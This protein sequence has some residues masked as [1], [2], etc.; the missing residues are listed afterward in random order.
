M[1]RLTTESFIEKSRIVH[2]ETYDYSKVIY[3]NTI[4]NVII[5]CRYHGEFMQT[6]HNHLKGSGCMKC[7]NKRQSKKISE[8]Y[9]NKRI[10]TDIVLPD[11]YK[12][13]PVGTK[14]LVTIVD[15]EYFDYLSKYNWCLNKHGYVNNRKLGL[16]HRI[17]T[18]CPKGLMVDHKDH[19]KLNNRSNNLRICTSSRNQF[20]SISTKG[21]SIYK[22]VCWLAKE[23]RW[24]ANIRINR[25][26]IYLGLF[27]NEDDAA[28]AYNEAAILYF[29][30][31]AY[32]NE[33]K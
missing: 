16:I 11:R 17:I 15:S 30:D 13:I 20:N 22:G 8:L 9:S 28:K 24:A 25:K 32:L 27:K 33:I 31:F 5:S 18:K 2:G 29:K 1:K 7:G 14:G 12:A 10:E 4:T 21:T 26:R 6:P 23:E 3:N 19:D